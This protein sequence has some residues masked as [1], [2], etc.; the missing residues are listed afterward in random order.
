MLT[1]WVQH[2]GDVKV[3]LGDIECGVQVLERVVFG[4]FAV[5]DEVGPVPV[6]E[7]AEGQAVLEREVEV[8]HVDVLVW[9]SLALAPEKQTFL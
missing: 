1:V 2:A 5:V 7:G 6:D 3:F 9:C 4:E 8:L